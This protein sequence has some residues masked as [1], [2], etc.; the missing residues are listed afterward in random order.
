M[1]HA[2]AQAALH[3]LALPCSARARKWAVK[4]GEVVAFLRRKEEESELCC[5]TL[6]S[7]LV[8]AVCDC[9]RLQ[10]WQK[11]PGMDGKWLLSGCEAKSRSDSSARGCPCL[12]LGQWGSTDGTF[13]AVYL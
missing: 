12:L 7:L 8:L 10:G 11:A 9:V 6:V 1:G 13:S 4:L 2:G 5:A 3:P